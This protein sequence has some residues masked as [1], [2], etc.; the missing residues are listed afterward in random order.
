MTVPDERVCTRCREVKP[1]DQFSAAPRGKY[2]RKSTCKDCDHARYRA[3]HPKRERVRKPLREPLP[4]ETV[5]VCSRC[6]AAKTLDEFSLSRK[7]TATT[8]AVYRSDCK[9]CC[10]ERAMEWFRTHPERTSATKRRANLARYGLTP[11]KYDS[12]LSDQGGVCAVC[13]NPPTSKDRW[14]VLVVDHDHSTGAVRGLLCHSCNRALGL[15]GDDV[16]ILKRMI[17]YLQ[18]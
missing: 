4:G 12:I 13:R 1:L 8:N 2:G 10:S 3:A 15:L 18:G 11:E 6:R 9:T 16:K 5:K 7:A 17:E 14:G